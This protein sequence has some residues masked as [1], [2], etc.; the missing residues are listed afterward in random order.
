MEMDKKIDKIINA[1]TEEE[2]GD[3]VSEVFEDLS[4]LYDELAD[5]IYK[6]INKGLDT[7]GFLAK[8][9]TQALLSLCFEVT[10]ECGPFESDKECTDYMHEII[11]VWEHRKGSPLSDY[12]MFRIFESKGEKDEE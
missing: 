9:S 3:G 1:K 11:D 4:N 2:L 8:L 5:C 12:L 6:F 7:R 10:K